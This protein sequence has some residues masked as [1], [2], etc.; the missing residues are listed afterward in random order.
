MSCSS[1]TAGIVLLVVIAA[2]CRCAVTQQKEDIVTK[3][4]LKA[5]QL[6][7]DLSDFSA[8]CRTAKS[9]SAGL[10]WSCRA[11]PVLGARQDLWGSEVRGEIARKGRWS[12]LF[13]LAFRE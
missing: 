2:T 12:T 4:C 5:S 6:E 3:Q 9:S 10:G 8:V 7:K 13:L 1:W 11:L